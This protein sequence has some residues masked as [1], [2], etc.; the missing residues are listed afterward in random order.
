[1]IDDKRRLQRLRIITLALNTNTRSLQSKHKMSEDEKLITD[2]TTDIV[3]SDGWVIQ[4]SKPRRLA[5][6][7]T[8]SRQDLGADNTK[9]K[10]SAQETLQALRT[11][12]FYYLKYTFE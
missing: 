1:M 9:S 8:I 5:P 11:R 6:Q 10:S 2:G 12:G 4:T 3:S 7:C